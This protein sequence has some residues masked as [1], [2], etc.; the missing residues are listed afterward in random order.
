MTA[1]GCLILETKILMCYQMLEY[2]SES[3][4]R[5]I[6]GWDKGQTGALWGEAV[7]ESCPGRHLFKGQQAVEAVTLGS[8]VPQS[9]L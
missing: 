2:D 5:A 4:D 1:Q 8:E 6:G 7:P 3:P 9:C